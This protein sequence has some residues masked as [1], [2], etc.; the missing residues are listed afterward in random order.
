MER[1][2]ASNGRINARNFCRFWITTFADWI[3]WSSGRDTWP[4]A[5]GATGLGGVDEIL[6]VRPEVFELEQRRDMFVG[7][8]IAGD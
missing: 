4:S 6:M 2:C 8:A 7:D 5:E 3:D 1:S